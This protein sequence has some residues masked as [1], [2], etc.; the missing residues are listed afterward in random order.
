MKKSF[1]VLFG[2]TLLGLGLT[3]ISATPAQAAAG[4]PAPIAQGAQYTITGQFGIVQVGNQKTQLYTDSALTKPSGTWVNPGTRWRYV[5][6]ATTTLNSMVTNFSYQVGTNLWVPASGII[7]DSNYADGD[8]VW[9]KGVLRITNKTGAQDFTDAFAF[10]DY[11]PTTRK[12][13]YGSRWQYVRAIV[14]SAGEVITYQIGHTD[15]VRPQDVTVEAKG[16]FTVQS[17]GT[18]SALS[19]DLKYQMSLPANSRWKTFGVKYAG[20]KLFYK[21]ATDTYVDSDW[22]AWVPS[23]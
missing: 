22:G 1:I 6:S 14:D 7:K 10:G 4:D 3:T 11:A 20:G 8:N 2:A 12:F 5:H 18:V 17:Y 23:K 16:I 9:T 15:F 13:A 21:I 19:G